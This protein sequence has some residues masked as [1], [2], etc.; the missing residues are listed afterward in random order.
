VTWHGVSVLVTG[1]GGFIGSHLAERLAREGAR[2]RGFVRYN[3]RRDAGLLADVAPE[4]ARDIEIVMGDL[5]DPESVRR[6]VAGTEVVFHLAA[7]VGIPYSYHAPLDYVQT[8]VLGTAHLLAAA[9]EAGV[10]RVVQT[11]TSEVYGTAQYAPMDERHPLQGQSPYAASKIAADK[12]AESY[13]RSF[14]LPVA[15]IRPFNTYGPRQSARAVI[16]TIITQ[17]LAGPTVRLGALHPTRDL[18]YVS[19]IVEGFLRVGS[20][21]RAVGEV[22]NVG[23]GREL[24]VE[25]LVQV[26]GRALGTPLR[27]EVEPERVRPARSEVERLLCDAARAREILGW[28]PAVS[29]EGGIAATIE[30]IRG[31]LDRYP[32]GVYVL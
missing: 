23:A 8:N 21:A 16:P 7:L 9:R 6:A 12:L 26:V 22:F 1:A 32:S 10:R 27:I 14:D 20:D 30:W 17:A 15:T 24:A 28:R 18:T 11:S 5:K 13:H 29:L 4:A 2:V 3:S 19:D 31:H 25:D